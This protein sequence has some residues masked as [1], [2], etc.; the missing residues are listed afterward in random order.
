MFNLNETITAY[1]Q[2][3]QTKIK[4]N[5]TWGLVYLHSK[6]LAFLNQCMQ[7]IQGSVYYSSP[8]VTDRKSLRAAF[9]RI[10][11]QPLSQSL[12]TLQSIVQQLKTDQSILRRLNWEENL[13]A[14]LNNKD[15]WEERFNQVDTQPLTQRYLKHL[16][17]QWSTH[18]SFQYHSSQGL[19]FLLD[20][21]C[22]YKH[23]FTRAHKEL[24][25]KQAAWLPFSRLPEAIAKEY[26]LFLE[27]QL[28]YLKKLQA[29]VL[30][31]LL[32]RLKVAEQQNQ[33][34]C[35]DVSY[36]L[37]QESQRLGFPFAASLPQHQITL[38]ISTFNKIHRAIEKYG[39]AKQKKQLY[40]LAWYEYAEFNSED[41]TLI[42]VS[43]HHLLAPKALLKFLPIKFLETQQ[44]LLA[45]L[46]LPLQFAKL[47]LKAVPI[48][49]PAL[50]SLTAR[51]QLLQQSLESLKQQPAIRW[52]QW[53]QKRW[54]KSWR[55]WLIEQ[56]HKNQ[57]SLS[58]CLTDFYQQVQSREDLLSQAAYR[59]KIQ[60]IIQPI[61]AFIDND[62]PEHQNTL[63][64]TILERLSALLQEKAEKNNKETH[65][66]SDALPHSFRHDLLT[67][68]KDYIRHYHSQGQTIPEERYPDFNHLWNLLMS[69]SDIV[70]L[71]EGFMQCYRAMQPAFFK[72]IPALDSSFLRRSLKAVLENPKYSME[73]LKLAAPPQ[74]EQTTYQETHTPPASSSL[75]DSQASQNSPEEIKQLE[76]RIQQLIKNMACSSS[77]FSNSPYAVGLSI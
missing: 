59:E 12:P 3:H 22:E 70:E 31:T 44:A 54:K 24:Q 64:T 8:F 19:L 35:D 33:V 74:A 63:L 49:H 16:Q 7:L 62:P 9:A 10:K 61:H 67:A 66:S 28:N 50:R 14:L 13:S 17:E 75:G 11:E 71:R 72:L 29:Q 53:Q 76:T 52:W 30:E 2:I 73:Q 37:A 36:F 27:D 46:A 32:L 42:S 20:V 4:T 65:F 18:Q 1:N 68:L 34:T 43:Q 60:R 45:Q 38:D 21:V 58:D 77:F 5:K 55:A 48:E 25:S 51:Y 26:Y 23:H 57:A 39:N 47:P 15:F 41:I 40:Q 6:S 56:F 69:S